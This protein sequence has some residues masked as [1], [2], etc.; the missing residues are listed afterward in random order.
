MKI[1][2]NVFISK[3]LFLSHE[4]PPTIIKQFFENEMSE[5]YLWHLPLICV[6]L[7]HTHSNSEKRKDACKR[8]SSV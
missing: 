2:R 6:S 3:I 5:I 4:H 8:R 7:S 1:D